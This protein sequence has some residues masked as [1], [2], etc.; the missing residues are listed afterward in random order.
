MLYQHVIKEME[1]LQEVQELQVKETQVVQEEEIH[2]I[3]VVAV[4]PEDTGNL[5]LKT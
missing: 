2:N 5:L 3:E 1:F 4:E